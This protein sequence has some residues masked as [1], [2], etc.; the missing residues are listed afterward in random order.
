MNKLTKGDILCR[1]SS[2]IFRFVKLVHSLLINVVLESKK[3]L[4]L[5]FLRTSWLRMNVSRSSWKYLSK[6]W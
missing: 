5:A 1:P 4:T 2:A 3:R 6:I